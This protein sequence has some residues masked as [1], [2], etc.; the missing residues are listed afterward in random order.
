M[1]ITFLVVGKTKSPHWEALARDYG[2]RIRRFLPCTTKV[3]REAEASIAADPEQARARE[4]KNILAA[5]PAGALVVLLDVAGEVVSSEA[6]AKKLQR[7]RE[8]GVRDLYFV[9]GGHWGV[10]AEVQGRA[11]WRWSLS[12]LTF[13]H[14]MARVLA[15]EQVYRALARLANLPYAK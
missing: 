13:T 8:T 15:A 11:A 4:A 10:T 12:R 9:I 5:L 7:W 1:H 3:V 14:E 2:E 6:F